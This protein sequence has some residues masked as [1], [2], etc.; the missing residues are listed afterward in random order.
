MND[1][2]AKLISNDLDILFRGKKYEILI[3]RKQQE[4]AHICEM[5][6]STWRFSNILVF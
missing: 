1:I 5:T 6:L 3:S 2:I 4:L